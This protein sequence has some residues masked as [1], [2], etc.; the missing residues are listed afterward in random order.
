MLNKTADLFLVSCFLLSSCTV[1]D[2]NQCPLE[3]SAPDQHKKESNRL[4][5]RNTELKPGAKIISIEEVLKDGDDHGRFSDSDYVSIEGYVA[6]IKSGGAE[7]CNCNSTD[8]KSHDVH[9]YIGKTGNDEKKDCF[10]AEATPAFKAK[11]SIHYDELKG[12][13]VRITGYMLY[14]TEHKGSAVNSCRKCA[15]VWRK[16]VWEIHPVVKLEILE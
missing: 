4:K 5:N 15:N 13:K 3:G 11:H 6:Q 8:E 2:Q 7:S 1:L 16:T 10:I 14:D 12:K 9:L